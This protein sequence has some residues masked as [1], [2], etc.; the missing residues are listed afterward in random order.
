M[1]L[2]CV[3]CDVCGKRMEGAEKYYQVVLGEMRTNSTA[4]VGLEK[5]DV[6]PYCHDQVKK[7]ISNENQT[8]RSD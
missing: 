1:K 6:C 7:V 5:Y 4:H 8:V 2:G 3:V